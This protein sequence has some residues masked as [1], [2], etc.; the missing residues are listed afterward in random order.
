[1]TMETRAQ[2]PRTAAPAPNGT[3]LPEVL[4]RNIET[5]MERRKEIGN[6]WLERIAAAATR[7]IGSMGFL[8]AHALLFG[9]WGLA[10]TVGLPGIPVF[11]PTFVLMATFASVE[12]IF[13]S[14]L[15]LIAQNR[16]SAAADKRAEL[17]LQISLLTE[18]ELTRMLRLVSAIADRLN[19]RSEIDDEIEEL[20][21]DVPLAEVF[22][23]I[24]HG[25]GEEGSAPK[26]ASPP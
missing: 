23:K 25:D 5:L 13:L 19:V 18:H 11:D 4:E 24:E 12:A 15:V 10:N 21:Q 17:D 20:K 14:T 9:L 3:P 26:D 6:T 1:M 22:D 16:M 7:Y 8:A 2:S